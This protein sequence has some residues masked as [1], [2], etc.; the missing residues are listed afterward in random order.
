M[1]Q[2]F[3]RQKEKQLKVNDGRLPIALAQVKDVNI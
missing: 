2:W 3:L 1:F